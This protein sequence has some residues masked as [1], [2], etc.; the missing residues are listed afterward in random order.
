[1]HAE[2][3]AEN[4][5]STSS[6]LQH[7]G[8]S[9]RRLRK[10][11]W[12]NPLGYLFIAPALILYLVFNFWVLIR[13]FLMAFTNYEFLVPGSDWNWDGLRNFQEA[14][15]DRFFGEAIRVSLQYIAML[16]PSLVVL[17]LLT[18]VAIYRVRHGAAFLR[19]LVYLPVIIPISVSMLLWSQLYNNQYGLI[20]TM[21]Q[22]FGLHN[23]PNWLGS[24]HTA[25]LSVAA[26]SLWHSFGFPTLLFLV[27][28]YGISTDLYEAA[29]V[30][31]ANAWQQFWHVTLPSL[32][33]TFALVIV[34]NI[35]LLYGTQEI[36]LLTGGGPANATQTVG[37]YIYQVAFTEGNLRLGYAASLSL[38]VGIVL[39]G[40][41][42]ATLRSLRREP[43]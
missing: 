36:L 37:F 27:G 38:I 34:L 25:L 42:F 17:S 1:M 2:G 18:A 8:Q 39:M 35:G 19:W 14:F 6:A 28:L 12:G 5:R 24:T 40:V 15:H 26:A 3:Q 10:E 43:A 23:P 11:E 20:D 31:G 22:A 4:A 9:V 30:D 13:G 21:L 33:P 7:L 16:L 32:R 29:A 41:S